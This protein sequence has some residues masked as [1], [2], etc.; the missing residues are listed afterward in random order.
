[1]IMM[2][3][4]YIE[5]YTQ[6]LKVAARTR[7]K[8]GRYRFDDLEWK[9][10]TQCACSSGW[11]V[12]KGGKAVSKEDDIVLMVFV[13]IGRHYSRGGSSGGYALAGFQHDLKR[14]SLRTGTTGTGTGVWVSC[15]PY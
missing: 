5:C 11:C 9:N 10:G 15:C 6:V 3:E 12:R 7:K 4:C 14:R 8:K 2:H 13:I 1:M